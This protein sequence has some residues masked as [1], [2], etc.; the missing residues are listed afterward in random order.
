MSGTAVIP[1]AGKDKIAAMLLDRISYFKLGE[2]GF[3]L[4]AEVTEV[5]DASAS[6]TEDNY[7]H[8]VAGG[9]FPITDVD[10]GS[11]EFEISGEY[12]EFF[13]DGVLITVVDSTGN[14]GNYTVS[15]GG[16][17]EGGGSTTIEVNESIPSATVDGNI[18][19]SRLP[20]AI[21]PTDDSTHYPM[22][23][24]EVTPGLSVVQSMTDTTGEG[25]L[26]GDG[27]GTVNY[28]SGVLDVTFSSLVTAGNIVRIRWKYHDLKKDASGG[29]SYT[30]LESE[31]SPLA[32][33][34][35]PE[36]YTYTKQF[37]ADVDTK[38]VLRGT[39]YATVRCEMK[40]Q[41]IEGID[42]GRGLTYGGTPYY[43]EGGVFDDQDVMIGY[44]TFDKERKTAPMEVFHT[45]DFVF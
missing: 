41:S 3:V 26:T 14:N 32:P 10:I 13:P 20:I 17:Y 23:V 9:D 29:A 44:F 31:G 16:V 40:L 22:V 19:V 39:G 24:E 28:K 5:I 8:T 21:G 12:A 7:T 38:V 11:Q 34:G 30:E 45:F 27:T 33:D 18:F 2:G 4:S 1:S 36:L 43:F 42:D 6:G 25:A 35:N 15:P 37:G